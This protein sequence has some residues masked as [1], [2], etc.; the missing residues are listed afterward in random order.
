MRRSTPV[1]MSGPS[2]H[3][4]PAPRQV[5]GHRLLAAHLL[6][7]QF[8]C[9]TTQM[10]V[11]SVPFCTAH[12]PAWLTHG[13]QGAGTQSIHGAGMASGAKPMDNTCITWCSIVG[14]A[15]EIILPG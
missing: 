7:W 1:T 6:V 2:Q 12:V 15:F 4:L 14:C 10:I 8:F 5:L 9:E 13:A 11:C 3:A